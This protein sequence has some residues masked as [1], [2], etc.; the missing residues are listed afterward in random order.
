MNRL[1]ASLCFFFLLYT[2]M[3]S[4][5][6]DLYIASKKTAQATLANQAVQ[7]EEKLKELAR[8]KNIAPVNA[9]IDPI[10]KGIPGYNGLQ[11]DEEKT[12]KRMQQAGKW[13][14]SLIVFREVKPAVH[15]DQL[16]SSPIY[17]G[18]PEK[19]MISVM[20]NVAWGNEYLPSILKTLEKEKVK[21]TFF[22]DGS[23]TKKYPDEAKKIKEAGHEIGSHAYSHPNMSQLSLTR[24][25]QEITKTNAVI[26]QATGV[27]PTLFAPP[28]GD[29]D[30]RVVDMAARHKL[31]TILWTADTIDWRKPTPE[32][33]FR[34]VAPKIN[35][36]VLVLMHPTES[37]DKALPR[38]I[39]YAKEK[40][41]AL[42][43]VS[44]TLSTRRVPSY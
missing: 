42:G 22:L 38:L 6:V 34:T 32:Q 40:K 28:S 33:W 10:W 25:E 39:Q 15:I 1:L 37:T 4:E 20:I 14:E 7:W 19:P 11:I 29:F 16:E 12:I 24:M 26:T 5:S 18:N 23:W 13:D 41:L 35:N 36:G 3:T 2:V 17:R 43:T 8:T 9:R 21:A 27:T 30:Q 44:E 31:K